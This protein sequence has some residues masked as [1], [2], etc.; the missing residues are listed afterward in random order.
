LQ[1]CPRARRVKGWTWY[2][3]ALRIIKALVD[4]WA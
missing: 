1:T 3:R 2:S 4:P